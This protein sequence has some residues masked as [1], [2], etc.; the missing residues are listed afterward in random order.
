[1]HAVL[2]TDAR[3]SNTWISRNSSGF[4]NIFESSCFPQICF[5]I[6]PMSLKAP[7]R[8]C[9]KIWA[10]L[11]SS[12]E[13]DVTCTGEG[14]RGSEKSVPL[15]NLVDGDLRMSPDSQKVGSPF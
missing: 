7:Q 2:N 12:N 10:L 1:M 8:G 9:G 11:I 3:I 13:I 15:V 5:R 4:L 14:E 6:L